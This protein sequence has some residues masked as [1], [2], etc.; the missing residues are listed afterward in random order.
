M[1]ANGA[2]WAAGGA[3]GATTLSAVSRRTSAKETARVDVRVRDVGSVRRMSGV[4]VSAVLV[5]QG[6]R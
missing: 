4:Q 3:I 5:G 6:R 2:T 1:I